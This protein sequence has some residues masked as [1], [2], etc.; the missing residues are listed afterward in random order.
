MNSGKPKTAVASC[1]SGSCRSGPVPLRFLTEPALPCA[2]ELRWVLCFGDSSCATSW[3]AG[4]SLH[5]RTTRRGCSATQ[6]EEWW[7]HTDRFPKHRRVTS[8]PAARPGPTPPS[9]L[10][11]SVRRLQNSSWFPAA[12]R[13]TPSSGENDWLYTRTAG[14]QLKTDVY[15][16][17][18]PIVTSSG[19]E[20]HDKPFSSQ[21][22]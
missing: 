6:S 2:A 15:K 10:S 4:A 8:S 17:I 3:P 14:H 16:S 19:R 9:S 12:S 18:E 22:T 21:W 11:S 20:I 7:P 1:W 5:R 13:A